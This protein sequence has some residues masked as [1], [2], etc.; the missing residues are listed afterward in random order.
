MAQAHDA[1]GGLV[2]VT[3]DVGASPAN[4]QARTSFDDVPVKLDG[5]FGPLDSHACPSWWVR[6]GSHAASG[7]R[8]RPPCRAVG[9]S[10]TDA[11]RRGPDRAARRGSDSARKGG[12]EARLPRGPGAAHRRAG[13][14]ERGA[15]K[16]DAR[17]DLDV[18]F[19]AIRRGLKPTSA[20][21]QATVT[22]R[23]F[24]LAFLTGF[25]TALRKV[26]GTLDIDAHA[27]GPR[28]LRRRKERSN[29]RNRN[30]RAIRLWRVPA[31]ASVGEREQRP[32]L[33]R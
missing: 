30:P 21:L 14:D 7:G 2:N 32:H 18:S 24:D 12:G 29:G 13:L 17:T 15:L 33:A 20:P 22:A 23:K 25:T 16:V 6:A 1:R 8:W 5:K 9:R 3:L 11:G 4:L 28:R 19:P 10:G 27:T 26:A 31:G